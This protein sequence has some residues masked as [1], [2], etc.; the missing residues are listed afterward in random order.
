MNKENNKKKK[1]NKK[2]LLFGLPIL[3]LGLVVAL[4]YYAVFSASFTVNPSIV[5]SEGCEDVLSDV[6]DGDTYAGSECT[7]TNNAPSD[8][9]LV[10]SNNAS[11][12]IEVSYVGELILAKKDISTWIPN[13]GDTKTIGYTIVGDS[14]EVTEIPEG[15][16]LIYY[17][18][19]DGDVF[20]TNIANVLVYDSDTIGNLPINL[21]VG[22]DYCNN[23]FNLDATQC[24]G[25]KLWLIEG[26]ESTALA[27]LS[28]WD[29]SEF[30]FETALI[31]Y[32]ANGE[33]TLS[34]GA[35]LTITPVYEIGAG[36]TGLQTIT[37]T[38][39]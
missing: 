22:D 35:S 15:Y 29:A 20:A 11:S 33:I 39:A 12:E 32:N 18:N 7:L 16:T 38:V 17:P 14:F 31:Q 25:A 26:D 24:V 21:D 3:A 30:Y 9:D 4:T 36:V 1:F 5:L 8:R 13:M 10:I 19:T 6:F 2:L 28:S 34:S 37:T 27:K 23:E